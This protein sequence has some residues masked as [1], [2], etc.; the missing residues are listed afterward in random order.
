[1]TIVS[2]SHFLNKTTTLPIPSSLYMGY[3]HEFN[4]N[5]LVLH[6]MSANVCIYIGC[7]RLLGLFLIRLEVMQSQPKPGL[8][9][10]L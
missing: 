6:V 2:V 9:S 5:L 10:I 4:R 8:Y 7:D 3:C 1:M